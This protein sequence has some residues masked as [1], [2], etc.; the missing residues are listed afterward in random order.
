M[1]KMERVF[2]NP[3]LDLQDE[4]EN[5]DGKNYSAVKRPCRLVTLSC[6]FALLTFLIVIMQYI[7][8]LINDIVA[9]EKFWQLSQNIIALYHNKENKTM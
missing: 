1:L 6:W 4:D 3:P 8:T 2:T 5:D 7:T 9:N